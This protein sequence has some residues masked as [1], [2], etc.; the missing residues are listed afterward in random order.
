MESHIG[1]L[2]TVHAVSSLTTDLEA[3]MTDLDFRVRVGHANWG[4][5]VCRRKKGEMGA[6]Q[7]GAG[8][9]EVADCRA[10][11]RSG[12]AMSRGPSSSILATRSEGRWATRPW[13]TQVSALVYIALSDNPNWLGPAP[14]EVVG[15]VGKGGVEKVDDIVTV[16]SD[17]GWATATT[18]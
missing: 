9:G 18:D 4:M 10:D 8:R 16:L 17:V 11:C 2:R 15:H 13:L 3:V 5:C 6:G 14:E 12:G 1:L 7:G